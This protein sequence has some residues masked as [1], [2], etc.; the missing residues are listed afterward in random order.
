M[1][2]FWR[3]LHGD[4]SYRCDRT[5][6]Q[7]LMAL[8]WSRKQSLICTYQPS[9]EINTRDHAER[10][11]SR[12][13]VIAAPIGHCQRPTG[14]QRLATCKS[15]V[16]STGLSEL[17]IFTADRHRVVLFAKSMPFDSLRL[18]ATMAFEAVRTTLHYT[19]IIVQIETVCSD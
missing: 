13:G 9:S 12:A 3:T 16:S 1:L 5:E 7:L 14:T 11:Y 19:N 15:K 4:N 17:I 8:H 10:R 6:S 2:A 18:Q